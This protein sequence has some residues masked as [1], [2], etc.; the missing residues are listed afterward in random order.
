MQSSFLRLALVLGL[1][2]AVGPFAIDMYLPALPTIG[3]ALGASPGAVQASLIVFFVALGLGQVIYGPVS[4]MVGRKPPLYF[5]LVLFGAGSIG[6]ALAPSVE[7]LIALRFVQGLG[8][9]A[10]M[11]VPRAKIGRA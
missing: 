1:V 11:V 3:Q 9:C 4:D 5:G 6:C 2:S 8:A 10:G 7:A